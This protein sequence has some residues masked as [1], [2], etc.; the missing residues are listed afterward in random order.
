MLGIKRVLFPS[1][2]TTVKTHARIQEF[3]SGL[4]G[5]GGPGQSDN[6]SSDVFFLFFF[7]SEVK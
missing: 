2:G 5:G 4:G 3:L 6:K 7:F 1:L